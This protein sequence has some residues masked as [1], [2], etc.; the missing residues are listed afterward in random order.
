[1]LRLRPCLTVLLG[2]GLLWAGAAP[3]QAAARCTGRDMPGLVAAWSRSST[4]PTPGE[5]QLTEPAD[6]EM[7]VARRAA[8][9]D[10][11]MRVASAILGLDA[12]GGE[13]ELTRVGDALA[14]DAPLPQP[15]TPSQRSRDRVAWQLISAG[16]SGTEI[17]D[18]LSGR[19][20]KRDIDAARRL[21]LTGYGETRA[22]AFLETAIARREREIAARRDARRTRPGRRPPRIAPLPGLFAGSPRPPTL[23]PG[24]PTL[25]RASGWTMQVSEA[26]RR[27]AGVYGVDPVIIDAMVSTESGGDPGA[28]S[29]R[30]AV[31]L[32]QLMPATARMLGV[33]PLD[34]L[35]NLR[36]GISYFAGLL[37]QYG[38]VASAL[39][40]YN[41]G[42]THAD[43][44]RRGEAVLYGE[45]RRYLQRIA[46]LTGQ[47]GYQFAGASG[48]PGGH[49]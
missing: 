43:R 7:V 40:A 48:L 13:N 2:C 3:V 29:T 25:V 16:Y 21:L 44:V 46:G 20:L 19:V 4:V 14:K 22:A 8:E 37:R 32:M 34:P 9:W 39:I 31:G 27:Y 24:A 6:R 10:D 18:I 5:A 35:D 47:S 36:G 1:M 28:V 12:A 11:F 49:P 42:P 26:I 30:G 33:N 15:C 23:S 38:D 45:T 41:A 17:A